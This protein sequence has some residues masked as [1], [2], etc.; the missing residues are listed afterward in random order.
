MSSKKVSD[1]RWACAKCQ[2]MALGSTIGVGLFLG[3][4]SAINSRALY[5]TRLYRCRRH[6]LLDTAGI[7][8]DGRL[9]SCHR[10]LCV[11]CNKLRE[12]ILGYLVGWGY[13]FYWTIIAIAE[14]TAVGIYMQFWLP[15]SPQW[16]WAFASIAIMGVVNLF[17][18][19]VFG[20]FEL[21]FA[22]IKVVTILIMI[23]LGL[24]VIIFGFPGEWTPVR[25]Q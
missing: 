5:L 25:N 16:I 3:S 12:P 24:F 7:G 4:A 15:G 23:A 18:A 10:L 14:V 1:A 13:W 17:T 6:E 8:R 20:E 2:L 21:W 11:L 9:S 19:K 22:L